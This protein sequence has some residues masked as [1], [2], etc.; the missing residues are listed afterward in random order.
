MRSQ[1]IMIGAPMTWKKWIMAKLA[2]LTLNGTCRWSLAS[3]LTEGMGCNKAVFSV[4]VKFEATHQWRFCLSVSQGPYHAGP[5]GRGRCGSLERN[6]LVVVVVALW[7]L[8]LSVCCDG[9]DD[10]DDDDAGATIGRSAAGPRCRRG[11]HGGCG[12][13]VVRAGRRWW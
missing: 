11:G 4:G 8:L 12:G 13:D 6:R 5:D 7:R 3:A 1:R 2:T 9:D 10:G